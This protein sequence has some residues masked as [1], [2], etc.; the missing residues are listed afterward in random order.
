MQDCTCRTVRPVRPLLR[1]RVA[2]RV[3]DMEG[4]AVSLGFK[5]NLQSCNNNAKAHTC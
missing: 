1:S 2:G 4:E 3:A 5:S